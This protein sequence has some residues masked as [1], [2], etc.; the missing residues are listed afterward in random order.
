MAFF[1]AEEPEALMLPD[2]PEPSAPPVDVSEPE[3]LHPARVSVIAAAAAATVRDRFFTLVLL[4][5]FWMGCHE[6]G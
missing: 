1:W 4:V 2:R 3:S 5:V 6:R